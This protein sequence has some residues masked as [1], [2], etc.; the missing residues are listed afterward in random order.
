MIG[1]ERMLV[2]ES[3]RLGIATV[4]C[5]SVMVKT[6]YLSLFSQQAHEPAYLRADSSRA[7]DFMCLV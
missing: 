5:C 1:L 6:Q 4:D 3:E 7:V 2:I